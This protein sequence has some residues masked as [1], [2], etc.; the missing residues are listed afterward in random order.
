MSYFMG[1]RWDHKI[2]LFDNFDLNP[3]KCRQSRVVVDVLSFISFCYKE[4]KTSIFDGSAYVIVPD[5]GL[6]K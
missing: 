3:H 6:T 1:K 4:I 5:T 2:V